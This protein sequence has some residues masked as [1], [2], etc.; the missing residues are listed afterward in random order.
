MKMAAL[1]VGLAYTM[2]ILTGICIS[3]AI[4]YK[5]MAWRVAAWP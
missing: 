3:L 1:P 5:R 4:N 2:T